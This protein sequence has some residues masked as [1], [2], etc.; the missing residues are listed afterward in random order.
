M[1]L[2]PKFVGKYKD[3]LFDWESDGLLDTVTQAWCMTAY[4]LRTD[5][6]FTFSQ[7]TGPEYTWH[8]D[9][10]DLLSNA[11][12]HSS[13]NGYNF[14]YRLMKLLYGT[15]FHI[16]PDEFNGDS[17]LTIYDTYVLSQ[18]A[19]P[20]REECKAVQINIKTGEKKRIGKH[21]VESY[22]YQFGLLKKEIQYWDT[23][24]GDI[25]DRCEYD[26]RIQAMMHRYLMKRLYAMARVRSKSNGKR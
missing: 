3:C 19:D 10:I 25:I 17:D 7:L 22:G 15:P 1:V 20:G 6:L 9:A 18:I 13:H 2:V 4:D 12:C 11:K 8:E 23:F 5:E 16:R 24:S 26:T 21:S 14:D